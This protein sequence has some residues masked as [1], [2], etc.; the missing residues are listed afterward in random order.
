M[1]PHSNPRESKSTA[2]EDM[3]EPEQRQAFGEIGRLAVE[4]HPPTKTSSTPEYEDVLRA[5]R[6]YHGGRER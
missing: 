2:L 1:S 4:K 3:L 6:F 5:R